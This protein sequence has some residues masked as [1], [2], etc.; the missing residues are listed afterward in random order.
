MMTIARWLGAVRNDRG[1]TLAETLVAIGILVVGLVA[2]L[3][4]MEY[5]TASVEGARRSTT[6]LFL[7]EQRMEEVRAF[8]VSQATGQGWGNLTSAAFPA[9]DYGA[10][11]GYPGF[12]RVVAVTTN[13]GGSLPNAKQ[14]EVQVFYRQAPGGVASAETSVTLATL[15]VRRH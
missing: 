7:A 11:P 2:L 15:L 9:E 3:G 10:I 6:A 13:P 5:G 8:A 4:A 14:V 12:R 1:F